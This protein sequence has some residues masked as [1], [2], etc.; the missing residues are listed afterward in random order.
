VIA[1]TDLQIGQAS[2]V[3][4][5]RSLNQDSISCFVPED[6]VQ[7]RSKGALFL[8]ADG[9]GGHNAGEVASQEAVDC[10]PEAYYA[11]EIHDVVESL[12]Q[13]F[14]TANQALCAMA[15]DD[16]S[17]AGMGTTLVA[18]VLREDRAI[19]ANVGDSRA[20]LLRGKH[21]SQITVDHSW[22]EE[23]VQEGLL[24]RD[25]A[26][27]HPH[28]HLITRS[29]GTRPGV[30]VDLFDVD[31]QRGDLLLLCTDGLSGQVSDQ[32]MAQVVHAMSPQEA[33]ADLVARANA[34]GGVDNA[35]VVI[36]QAGRRS[37]STNFLPAL[38]KLWVGER[39]Q[40]RVVGWTA[41]AV[42]CVCTL[43]LGVPLLN[44]RLVGN[45]VA[46]PYPAPIGF[47][48]LPQEGLA[49]LAADLGYSSIEELQQTYPD[50]MIV[51]DQL[52]A[53]LEPARPGI[54]VVGLVRN[55]QCQGL[56]CEFRLE[57]AGE[58]YR[59]QLD[60]AFL[61]SVR[62]LK[63]RRIRVFGQRQADGDLWDARLLDLGARWWAWWQPAWITVLANGDWGETAW[64]YSVLDQNPYSIVPM[65]DYP[66]LQQG[67]RIL[68][69]GKWTAG[70]SVE[71]MA[72]TAGR[73]YR[74]DGEV[75]VPVQD[76]SGP[77][78]QPTVTLRPTDTQ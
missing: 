75:Y 54:F 48:A 67:D 33:A 74:L 38:G 40:K 17:K 24:T 68:A 52:E 23:Q 61:S 59:F 8:V 9:M 14:E 76:R 25:A 65:E 73:L 11:D 53:D 51:G 62:S 49:G 56:V 70:D 34:H 13:A 41:L 27:R 32:K 63:G 20:Y 12:R 78:P 1:L 18:A 72:F 55:W 7:F 28:R 58:V 37:S 47:D 22:V 31:L 4:H 50:E 46:A 35:S 6:E 77:A 45:P 39:R 66:A 29:L 69:S 44:Q 21:L 15:E 16:P 36:V 71:S 26:R 60:Q 2:D 43:I 42:F 57:M 10:V 3:G 64:V 5:V 30:E 19:V